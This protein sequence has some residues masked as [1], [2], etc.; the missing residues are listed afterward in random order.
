MFPPEKKNRLVK[1]SNHDFL[2]AEEADQYTKQPPPKNTKR[3]KQQLAQQPI[4][5]RKPQFFTPLYLGAFVLVAGLI[6]RPLVVENQWLHGYILATTTVITGHNNN[7]HII[8]TADDEYALQLYLY[9][10]RTA[11]LQN[12]SDFVDHSKLYTDFIDSKEMQVV[13]G[14]TSY[15]EANESAKEEYLQPFSNLSRGNLIYGDLC[16]V[17]QAFRMTGGIK[18]HVLLG[19]W[20]ENW[21]F[22][23]VAVPNRTVDWGKWRGGQLNNICDMD[24]FW[25][26]LNHTNVSA[27]FT[28][29]H[30]WLDQHPKVFSVPLGTKI[31]TQLAL[32]VNKPL[33]NRTTLLLIAQSEF[34]GR[35]AIAE[36]VIANFNGTIKNRYREEGTNFFDL[37]RD[38]KFHLCPSGLGMDSYRNYETITMGTIPIMEKYYRRDGWYRTY[39]KL[40]VLWVDHFDN[41]TPTL[42]EE[43]YPQILSRAR[44]YELERLTHQWWI[45]MIHRYRFDPPPPQEVMEDVE[46]QM[47]PSRMRRR[48]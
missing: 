3:M 36:S 29:Q 28:V 18:R 6:I 31:G 47:P 1:N 19:H 13:N 35:P 41:V 43:Q 30:R 24:D 4:K 32:E 16:G 12:A 8:L 37:L 15:L 5:K 40:P 34:G 46:W 23:S 7:H 25:W 26:Y 2:Q 27:I 20:N 48:L 11:L 38:S 42:L 17:I 9:N 22:F 14:W 21:G 10:Q 39:D 44:E 33:L 45:D